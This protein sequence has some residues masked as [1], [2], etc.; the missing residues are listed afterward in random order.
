MI[1]QALQMNYIKLLLDRGQYCPKTLKKR[2][3]KSFTNNKS[4]FDI[5][6]A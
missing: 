4:K 3:I 6:D 5:K 1:R 2:S